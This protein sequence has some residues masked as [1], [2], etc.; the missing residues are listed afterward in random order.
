MVI[1]L[2]PLSCEV[3]FVD[4]FWLLIPIRYHFS[5]TVTDV[6][7]T[8]QDAN[9]TGEQQNPEGMVEDVK[10]PQGG[11]V[12]AAPG[13]VE[14]QGTTLM[15]M[16]MPT[17]ISVSSS[18][19]QMFV[20]NSVYSMLYRGR[21]HRQGPRPQSWKCSEVWGGLGTCWGRCS[22]RSWGDWGRARWFVYRIF[23]SASW[24]KGLLL[25]MADNFVVFQWSLPQWYLRRRP[26]QCQQR[27]PYWKGS[28]LARWVSTPA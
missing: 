20:L 18:C 4:P 14:N 13:D 12:A 28:G 10:E 8:Q 17:F 2:S 1:A 16:I 19:F 5:Q 26:R 9:Q 6:N 23:T 27:C 11:G 24:Y 25:L 21:S 15:S 3:F 22:C 7:V